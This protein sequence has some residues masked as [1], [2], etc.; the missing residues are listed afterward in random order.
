MTIDAPDIIRG[1][2]NLLS[3]DLQKFKHFRS[4][5]IL[6]PQCKNSVAVYPS[7][8]VALSLILLRI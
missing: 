6:R 1:H 8:K 3:L 2:K 5:I 4:D 7:L